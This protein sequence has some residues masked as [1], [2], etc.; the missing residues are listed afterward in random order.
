M[1]LML[2][3]SRSVTNTFATYLPLQKYILQSLKCQSS[4][5]GARAGNQATPAPQAASADLL[6]MVG[7]G[8]HQGKK[9]L[10]LKSLRSAQQVAAKR[11][12][13][14]SQPIPWT[15]GIVQSLS[16]KPYRQVQVRKPEGNQ[17]LCERSFTG[18]G[19]QDGAVPEFRQFPPAETAGNSPAVKVAGSILTVKCR[20]L[21]WPL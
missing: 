6:G 10:H 9:L 15:P 20:R 16:L 19:P 3:E 7:E 17:A 14:I 21:W 18:E 1:C 13:K 5:M 2:K 8:H 11:Y 12:T 4:K